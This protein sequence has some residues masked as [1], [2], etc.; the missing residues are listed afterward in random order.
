M[1]AAVYEVFGQPLRIQNVP[2][3]VPGDD[4]VVVR[5]KA[6]GICRSDWHGWMG[7]D[8]DVRVPHVPGHEL[9]GV[10]EEAGR[11]VLNWRNGDRVTVPFVCGC[12]KCPQCASGNHHICDHQFQPGF[13]HWGA[14]AE[15]VAIDR[16]DSNLVGLPQ[17]IDF[18]TAAVLGCRFMTSFRAIVAQGR[19]L[20]G[21]WVAVHGCGGVGL[22]A[23]MIAGAMGAQVIGVD[24]NDRTLGLAKTLGAAATLNA[25]REKDIP[26]AIQDISGGGAHVSIDALGSV[27]TCRNSILCL[28][29]RGRHVQVGLMVGEHSDPSLPMGPV[30]GR[31]LELLGSHGMQA[32]RY[33]EMLRMIASGR[34]RPDRL[35][36]KTVT[37]EG[38][39]KELENMGT[40]GTTGITVIDRF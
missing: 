34:L 38:S 30:I 14:F 27:V 17:E 21:Q 25:G 12:G 10:I 4:A 32:H 35:L 11:K 7:H 1:K 29:K 33:P 23:V 9:A 39:M 24:I 13:T 22:S 20:P 31:E 40:F 26:K 18:V 37:L 3:P 19:V 5:V 16:A 2:D 6:C 15:Y 36:G 28:R 8:P